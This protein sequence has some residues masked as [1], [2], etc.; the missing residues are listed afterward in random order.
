MEKWN[1]AGFIR[2]EFVSPF[3]EPLW[4]TI[5]VFLEIMRC[6]DRIRITGE[7]GFVIGEVVD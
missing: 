3:Y 5:Q 2:F 4:N 7:N 6:K 1:E